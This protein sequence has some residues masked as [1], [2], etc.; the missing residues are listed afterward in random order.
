MSR[1]TN[2]SRRN[3]RD[4]KNLQSSLDNFF[5][6]GWWPTRSRWDER[7]EEF[8]P[9]SRLSE[10]KDNYYLAVDLPGVKKEEIKINI[11][12]NVLK[13]YGE[14]KDK[15]E[16]HR[17]HYSEIFYGSFTFSFNLPSAVESSKVRANYE[18]GVLNITIPKSA[19]SKTKEVKIE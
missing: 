1:N 10:D 4:L 14:R 2:P 5:N 8:Q 19:E 18:D 17:Q 6:D 9:L 13:I 12:D 3:F 7:V 16:D 15:K 11:E